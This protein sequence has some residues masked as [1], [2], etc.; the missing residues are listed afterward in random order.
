M[1]G[2]YFESGNIPTTCVVDRPF[3]PRRVIWVCLNVYKTLYKRQHTQCHFYHLSHISHRSVRGLDFGMNLHISLKRALLASQPDIP[4]WNQFHM[5]TSLILC[6]YQGHCYS[7]VTLCW[8][9]QAP[10]KGCGASDHNITVSQK[11]LSLQNMSKGAL[12][13]TVQ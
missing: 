13:N 3:S 2:R 6:I 4:F 8:I 1:I 11:R 12:S 10:R 5:P 9:Y 7:P